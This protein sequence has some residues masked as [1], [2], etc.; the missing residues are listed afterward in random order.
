MSIF[1]RPHLKYE[2]R[3]K[4][5]GYRVVAG[6]D[7]VGRGAWAGPMVAAAVV[8][9][10]KPR[11]KGVDDSKQLTKKQREEVAEKIIERALCYGIG[12]VPQI[13]LDS[14]GVTA[15]NELAMVRAVGQLEQQPDYL[16]IDAF[17][18][19]AFPMK[20][21]SIPHGDATVY[22]IAA[23]SIIAKVYRDRMMDQYHMEFPLYGFDTNKGYGTAE[24]TAAL[25]THGMCA[26]H[27]RS[28][29]PMRTMIY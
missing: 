22:S 17:N 23:A 8:M 29:Q 3:L 9:P 19:Q 15:A 10:L 1:N 4:Q 24:H 7:E 5:E 27:R 18:T 28:F 20:H 11:I 2:K 21:A 12:I 13:E 6:V 16:L 14:I 25:D 26:I